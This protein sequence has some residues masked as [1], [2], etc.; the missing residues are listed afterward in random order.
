MVDKAG[1]RVS[2]LEQRRRAFGRGRIT[3]T[4]VSVHRRGAERACACAEEKNCARCLVLLNASYLA[5]AA[6]Q[7]QN[8]EWHETVHI[9]ATIADSTARVSV[10]ESAGREHQSRGSRI[11]VFARSVESKLH[12]PDCIRIL[13]TIARRI[14]IGRSVHTQSGLVQSARSACIP[15]VS[16]VMSKH[17]PNKSRASEHR[18]QDPESVQCRK[19]R[20]GDLEV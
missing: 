20:P 7:H 2:G 14:Q 1:A 12:G 19:C 10:A 6:Y 4:I 18:V 3:A 9:T 11:G 16:P 5:A 15:A 13:N 8:K 17:I